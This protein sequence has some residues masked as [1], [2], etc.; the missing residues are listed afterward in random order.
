MQNPQRLHPDSLETLQRLD[1]DSTLHR[2]SPETVQSFHRDFTKPL[3][4][5]RIHKYVA[6]TLRRFHRDLSETLQRL[7]SKKARESHNNVISEIDVALC[8]L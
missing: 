8:T 1:K 2:D 4:R 6:E 5:Q 7:H 3:Q